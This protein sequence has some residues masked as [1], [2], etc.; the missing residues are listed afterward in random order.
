MGRFD[1]IIFDCDGVLVDSERLSNEVFAA[2]LNEEGCPVTLEFMYESFVG[3]SMPQCL[4][5]IKEL[6][7][8]DLGDD[9]VRRYRA[10]VKTAFEADLHAVPGIEAVVDSLDCPYC[11]ASSGSHEKMKT[12]LGITGLI[13]K[14]ANHRFSVSEVK[15]SKPAPDV[16]LHAAKKMGVAPERCA[17]IE[18]SPTGVRAGL[19]AGMTVFAFAA[20]TPRE[21]L[22]EAGA[23]VIFDSMSELS[24]LLLST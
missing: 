10:R 11:V 1:L 21:R 15:E 16:F 5:Q 17:V 7:N 9:F 6:W 2:M 22:Q 18:D 20:R 23:T 14:F 8:K 24:G 3:K 13:S 12:T 19:A 4:V